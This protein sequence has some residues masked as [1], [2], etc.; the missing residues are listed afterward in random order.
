MI[1]TDVQV[2]DAQSRTPPA[3]NVRSASTAQTQATR[4]KV[5]RIAA[6]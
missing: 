5:P 2:V 1:V 3:T 4:A 6:T